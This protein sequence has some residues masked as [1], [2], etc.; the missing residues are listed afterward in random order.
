M[1]HFS[2]DKS[3][4]FL[5]FISNVK[6]MLFT[7]NL[8]SCILMLPLLGSFALLI[9]PFYNKKVLIYSEKSRI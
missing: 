1:M 9:T 2:P 4:D 5:S 6:K 3:V 7:K 8:L